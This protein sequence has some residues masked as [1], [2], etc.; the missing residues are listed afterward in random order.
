MKGRFIPAAKKGL[1]DITA[2]IKGRYVSIEVKIGKDT[3]KAHQKAVGAEITKAGGGYM[4][5]RNWP[6]FLQKIQPFM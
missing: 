5:V 4:V 2:I 1:G 6:E 3:H